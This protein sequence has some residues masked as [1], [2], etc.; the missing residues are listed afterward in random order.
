LIE[1]GLNLIW[2]LIGLGTMVNSWTLGLIG[3][4]GP[5]SGLFPMICGVIIA[6][7][8][9]ALLLGQPASRV[10]DPQW[11]RGPALYRIGGVSAGLVGMAATLP[12]LGFAI[13]SAVTT[14]VL[15][16]TVERSRLIESLVLSVVS[17]ALVIYLFGNVLGMSLPRGPWGW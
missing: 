7:C 6:I 17:V 13:A 3:P 2:C 16:Q 5:E 12:Y 9:F 8:G 4:T 11:P 15:L 1:R 10:C 14:F